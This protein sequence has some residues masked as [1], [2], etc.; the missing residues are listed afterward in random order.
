V[1]AL[2]WRDLCSNKTV[3]E[4]ENAHSGPGA[5]H[6]NPFCTAWISNTQICM[7]QRR[8]WITQITDST[9][10]NERFEG[11]C[12]RMAILVRP[13][14]SVLLY[15]LCIS[16]L[17]IYIVALFCG[18]G[19]ILLCLLNQHSLS[20]PMSVSTFWLCY[21]S[22]AIGLIWHRPSESP[23]F[24]AIQQS[25]V[26]SIHNPQNSEAIQAKCGGLSIVVDVS[27]QSFT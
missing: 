2:N 15:K 19:F 10:L 17:Y 14:A 20:P 24:T 22:L 25:S 1:S 23:L 3:D 16:K 12:W 21:V 6:E 8:T 5:G 7:D 9:I 18:S 26:W 4:G 27:A 11:H 13:L